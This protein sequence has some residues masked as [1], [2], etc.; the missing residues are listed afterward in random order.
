MEKYGRIWLKNWAA[1]GNLEGATA[2]GIFRVFRRE[3]GPGPIP[4]RRSRS[5]FLVFGPGFPNELPQRPKI[6]F[7][8]EKSFIMRSLFFA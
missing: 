7:S 6:Q 1:V 4:K 5:E 3:V 2:G 8:P